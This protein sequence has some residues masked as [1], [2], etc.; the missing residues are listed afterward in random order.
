MLQE[1]EEIAN[2]PGQRGID[3]HEGSLADRWHRRDSISELVDELIA[4][5]R[6]R[7]AVIVEAILSRGDVAAAQDLA[8]KDYISANWAEDWD[9]PEDS[10]Y[11]R[12]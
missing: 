12:A 10:V 1:R 2:A 9:S 4:T 11:N 5:G 3:S 8:V 7:E 6:R